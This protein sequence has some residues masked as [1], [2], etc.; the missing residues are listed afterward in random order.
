M[1]SA[2]LLG[3]VVRR[4]P[5]ES[6]RLSLPP[7]SQIAALDFDCWEIINLKFGTNFKLLK[8]RGKIYTFIK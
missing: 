1:I 3:W 2:I 4:E 8:M 6:I 5:Q 7:S